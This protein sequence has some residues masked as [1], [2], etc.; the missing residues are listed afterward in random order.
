MVKSQ[1]TACLMLVHGTKNDQ[2]NREEENKMSRQKTNN[3][4]NTQQYQPELA[5]TPPLWPQIE[6]CANRYGHDSTAYQRPQMSW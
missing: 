2:E 3:Y 5:K 6:P 4:A 1:E